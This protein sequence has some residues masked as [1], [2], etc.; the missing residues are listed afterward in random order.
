[1]S[2]HRGS[3]PVFLFGVAFLAV[4]AFMAYK[5]LQPIVFD[6]PAGRFWK[7][8]RP[9]AADTCDLSE[10]RAFQ[11]VKFYVPTSRHSY[12]CF[13][14]NL[15]KVDGFRIRVLAHGGVNLLRRDVERL[16]ELLGKPVW[17]KP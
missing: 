3:A 1:M 14:L 10:I 15:V 8:W 4:G 6:L 16:A 9:R 2:A 12:D 13:E 7:G 5:Y 11:I 17:E